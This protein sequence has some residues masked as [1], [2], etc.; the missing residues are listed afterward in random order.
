MD[1]KILEKFKPYNFNKYTSEEKENAV[2]ELIANI[3]EE[4]GLKDVDE[5][6]DILQE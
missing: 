4:K 1:F 5:A 3:I 6:C 2:K